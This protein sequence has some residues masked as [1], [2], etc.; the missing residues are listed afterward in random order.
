MVVAFGG[1]VVCPVH[2]YAWNVLTPLIVAHLKDDDTVKTSGVHRG[3]VDA[4]STQ[5]SYHV[6]ATL[7]T[8]RHHAQVCRVVIFRVQSCLVAYFSI[9]HLVEG[10]PGCDWK[11]PAPGAE[12]CPA[13]LIS[14]TKNHKALIPKTNNT[15]LLINTLIVLIGF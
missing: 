10:L 8:S 5:F 7:G 14:V 11:L 12:K 9:S 6:S 1:A 15:A 2:F 4:H 13:G 3:L